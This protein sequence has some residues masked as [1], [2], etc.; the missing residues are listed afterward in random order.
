M[1]GVKVL[2]DELN[3]LEDES[4]VRGNLLPQTGPVRLG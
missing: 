2:E 4:Q 3:L 1:D